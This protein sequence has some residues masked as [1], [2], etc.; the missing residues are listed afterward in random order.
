MRRPRPGEYGDFYQSYIDRTRG[1]DFLQNLEDSGSQMIRLFQDLPT[2]LRDYAY[3]K[4]KWSIARILRHL[5]DTDAVFYGR[6]LWLARGEGA[7]LPGFDHE[8]WSDQA[9]LCVNTWDEDLRQYQNQRILLLGFFHSIPE[10]LLERS[11]V[12]NANPTSLRSIPFIVA[13]HTFHHLAVLK[14]RYLK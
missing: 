5:I 12:I 11:A 13:G 1:A 4:G 9:E 10:E 8:K 6:A 2:H 7:D 3:A 14:E